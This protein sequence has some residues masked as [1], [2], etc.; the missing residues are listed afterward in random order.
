LVV[1]EAEE[2]VHDDVSS[3]CWKGIGQ[4]QWFFAAFAFLHADG[5]RVDVAV[6]DVDE[7]EDGAAREPVVLISHDS[8]DS[9]RRR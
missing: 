7:V 9:I 8:D 4:V 5:K 2:V 6:D 1:V 3:Q